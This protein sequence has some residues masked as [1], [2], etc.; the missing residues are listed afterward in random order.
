MLQ[1]NMHV[2]ML[3]LAADIL[4]CLYVIIVIFHYVVEVPLQPVSL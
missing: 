3:F 4:G 1:Q 2:E